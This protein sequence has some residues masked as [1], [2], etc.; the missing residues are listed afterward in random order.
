MVGG[1][2]WGIPPERGGSGRSPLGLVFRSFPVKTAYGHSLTDLVEDVTTGD[3]ERRP[4]RGGSL[5]GL[6]TSPEPSGRSPGFVGRGDRGRSGRCLHT[7]LERHDAL[8]FKADCRQG[9]RTPWRDPGS[10]LPGRTS[11]G[12][13][14]PRRPASRPARRRKRR[15]EAGS[16]GTGSV[17]I[18]ETSQGHTPKHLGKI[19]PHP[20][21]DR[22]QRGRCGRVRNRL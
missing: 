7:E 11:H 10:T 18:R 13:Q 3:A 8:D 17:S 1:Q 2:S 19:G 15:D 9:D 6:A 21:E 20:C 4:R 16:I 12:E 22:K 5:D 14:P